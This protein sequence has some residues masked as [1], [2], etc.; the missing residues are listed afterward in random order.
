MKD[1]KLYRNGFLKNKSQIMMTQCFK[2]PITRPDHFRLVYTRIPTYTPRS[3][4]LCGLSSICMSETFFSQILIFLPVI[5][6]S[7]Y[8]IRLHIK[9]SVR[10]FHRDL[11]PQTCKCL[12]VIEYLQK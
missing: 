4:R 3:R 2:R 11:Q 5:E 9:F 12:R 8:S 7:L 10:L 1:N 6:L